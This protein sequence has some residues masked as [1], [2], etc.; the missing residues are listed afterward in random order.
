VSQQLFDDTMPDSGAERDPVWRVTARF[1]SGVPMAWWVLTLVEPSDALAGVW[2]VLGL[3]TL[4]TVPLLGVSL[5]RASSRTWPLSDRMMVV[6][7]IVAGVA[8]WVA[9]WSRFN[10]FVW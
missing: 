5:V 6:V 7:G 4:L 1:A 8:V 2:L 9:A 3:C 10:S